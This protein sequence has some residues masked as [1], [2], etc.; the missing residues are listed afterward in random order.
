MYVDGFLT[1]D[2]LRGKRSQCTVLQLMER[3]LAQSI[4]PDSVFNHY[5]DHTNPD[6]QHNQSI[7]AHALFVRL[8]LTGQPLAFLRPMAAL[9]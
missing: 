1:D 9:V 5:I 3:E 2:F 7:A 6:Q 8:F 4:S